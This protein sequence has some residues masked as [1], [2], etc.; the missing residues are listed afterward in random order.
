MLAFFTKFKTFFNKFGYILAFIVI[1]VVVIIPFILLYYWLKSKGEKIILHPEIKIITVEN[2]QVY[3]E[4]A[5][6]ESI[7][8]A[9]GI[10]DRIKKS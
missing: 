1:I 7:V 3:N 2:P 5:L 4:G 8:I 9:K 10:L 6:K